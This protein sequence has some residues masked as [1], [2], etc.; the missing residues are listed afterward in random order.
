MKKTLSR[1]V[2]RIILTKTMVDLGL[3]KKRMFLDRIELATSYSELSKDDQRLILQAE[4][5]LE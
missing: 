1:R 2:A 3:R 5:E 4:K